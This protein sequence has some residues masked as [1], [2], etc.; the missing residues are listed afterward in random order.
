MYNQRGEILINV[1]FIWVG[2]RPSI[3]WEVSLMYNS[4]RSDSKV[5]W[6][7][8]SFLTYLYHKDRKI[9]VF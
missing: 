3:L 6:T 8:E 5:N 4:I 7:R 2:F 9:P 1:Y